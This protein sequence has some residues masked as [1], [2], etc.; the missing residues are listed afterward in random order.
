MRRQ[1]AQGPDVLPRGLQL[2]VPERVLLAVQK[3]NVAAAMRR[4]LRRGQVRTAAAKAFVKW[5]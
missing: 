5:L 2:P 1:D 3:V 4:R